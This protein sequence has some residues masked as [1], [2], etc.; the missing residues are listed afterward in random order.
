MAKGD[1]KALAEGYQSVLRSALSSLDS[2][3]LLSLRREIQVV[4]RWLEARGHED[5][6]QSAEGALDAVTSFYRFGQEVGGFGASNRAARSARLF[7]LASVG[8]LA[9]E[10]VLSSEKGTLMRLL[11]SALS[12]G[13]MFLGSRQYVAGS[14]AILTA[15]YR[16]HVLVV[17]DAL[18]ALA[19]DFRDLGSLEAIREARTAIE[20]LFVRLD[21]ADVPIATRVAL[22]HQ[23]Y[24]LVA[25]I[26]CAKLLEDVRAVR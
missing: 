12:E 18:W 19:S 3:S 11:M 14:E 2:S 1:A 26:R 8:I 6:V 20:A 10:N 15:T 4:L 16:S 22:L 7:D 13:L 5:A 23:L 24:G 9:V 25:I 21:E 17:Q